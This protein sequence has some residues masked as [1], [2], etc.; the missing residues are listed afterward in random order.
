[1][2]QIAAAVLGVGCALAVTNADISAAPATAAA[3]RIDDLE[4]GPL[5]S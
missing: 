3:S 4:V 2:L 5:I 1:V